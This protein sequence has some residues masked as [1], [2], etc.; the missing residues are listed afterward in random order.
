MLTGC[1]TVLLFFGG[2]G[3][4][5]AWN[6]WKAYKDITPVLCALAAMPSTQTIEIWLDYL[7]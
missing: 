7:E 6:T 3:K 1:D 5:T 4:K 2:R